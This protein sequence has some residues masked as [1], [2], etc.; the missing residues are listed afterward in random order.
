[1][2]GARRFKSP[3]REQMMRSSTVLVLVLASACVNQKPLFHVVVDAPPGETS[4]LYAEGPLD[5]EGLCRGH[6]P[7]QAILEDCHRAALDV[8]IS[9]QMV[10]VMCDYR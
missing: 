9:H 1:M 10:G 2:L 6:L 7:R 8:Q 4:A 3:F 5:C